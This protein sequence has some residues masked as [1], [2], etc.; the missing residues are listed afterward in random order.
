MTRF[1]QHRGALRGKRHPE[2]LW[3]AQPVEDESGHLG[4]LL[5]LH[6]MPGSCDELEVILGGK[7]PRLIGHQLGPEVVAAAQSERRDRERSVD[8]MPRVVRT[9]LNLA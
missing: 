5:A 9:R 8:R 3:F 2:S 4:R 1:R 7:V 6:E